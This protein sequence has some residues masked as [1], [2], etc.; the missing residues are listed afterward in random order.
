M[1]Q[2]GPLAVALIGLCGLALSAISFDATRQRQQAATDTQ[3][4]IPLWSRLPSADLSYAGGS[5]HLRHLSLEDP[6]AAFAD[7]PAAPDVDPAD[8]AIAPPTDAWREVISS[9]P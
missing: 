4:M 5:R 9:G 8:G 7:A 3:R 6:A 2:R 1:I